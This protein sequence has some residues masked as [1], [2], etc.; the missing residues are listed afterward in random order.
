MK[1]VRVRL[2]IIV[3]PLFIYEQALF[4]CRI[5]SSLLLEFK[6]KR[7]DRNLL[8]LNVALIEIIGE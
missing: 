3:E 7:S 6:V 8:H 2:V 4:I 1:V 5:H